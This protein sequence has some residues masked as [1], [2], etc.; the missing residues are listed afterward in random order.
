[1]KKIISLLLVFTLCFGNI[2]NVEA[3]QKTDKEIAIDMIDEL[4]KELKTI[5]HDG[6]YSYNF[7]DDTSKAS[8]WLIKY[9]EILDNIMLN[10]KK[11][12][13]RRYDIDY[14]K[15]EKYT[16]TEEYYDWVVHVD[17]NDEYY[18]KYEKVTKS[19]TYTNSYNNYLTHLNFLKKIINQEAPK[20][21]EELEKEYDTITF[22]SG[23]YNLLIW[24]RNAVWS[25]KCI[26]DEMKKY[27]YISELN[28]FTV[29]DPYRVEK[30]GIKY[31]L[32]N[33]KEKMGK[34]PEVKALKIDVKVVNNGL[35]ITN[36]YNTT[37]TSNKSINL[38][39]SGLKTK[40]KKN[41]ITVS[42]NEIL[43]AIKYQV[44]ISQKKNFKKYKSYNTLDPTKTIKKLKR[45]KTYYVR[46]RAVGYGEV[47]KWVVKK[48]KTK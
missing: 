6:C 5:G 31:L 36:I 24:E 13:D 3:K 15:L 42:F 28:F 33:C 32:D 30:N 47:G 44:Q 48:V 37:N 18:E 26:D 25:Y 16:K 4:I 11:A 19:K 17:E 34:L 22:K 46:V 41:K 20:S 2:S 29:T 43:Y 27:S 7:D 40:I 8:Y 14:Y 21:F 1:M 38:N 35:G 9:N 10:S 39:I 12:N 45:K 23:N